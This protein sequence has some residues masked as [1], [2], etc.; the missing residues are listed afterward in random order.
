[1]CALTYVQIG[2]EERCQRLGRAR[3]QAFHLLGVNMAASSFGWGLVTWVVGGRGEWL[4]AAAGV[5]VVG[6]IAANMVFNAPTQRL[7]HVFQVPL[8]LSSVTGFL[9]FGG[10]LGRFLAVVVVV[11]A[12][13]AASLHR[14]LH[15]VFRE[16]VQREIG[17]ADLVEQLRQQQQAMEAMNARLAHDATHDGLT[18]LVNRLLFREHLDRALARGPPPRRRRDGAVHG[19]RPVQGHQRLARPRCR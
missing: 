9:L 6:Y 11:F 17:N 4:Q 2:Y 15:T 5:Y 16:A 10:W 8:V 12:G 19:P 18:G 7:F 3:P 13:N 1:M 14:E